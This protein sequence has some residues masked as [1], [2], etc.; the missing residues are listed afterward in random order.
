MAQG[1]VNFSLTSSSLFFHSAS[2]ELGDEALLVDLVGAFDAALGLGGE[3]WDAEVMA[4][5]AEESAGGSKVVLIPPLFHCHGS[6][7]TL[8]TR[9][10]FYFGRTFL[11]ETLAF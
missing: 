11:R 7:L 8:V 6:I 3:G 2:A 9:E 5:L 1:V 4:Q 10:H